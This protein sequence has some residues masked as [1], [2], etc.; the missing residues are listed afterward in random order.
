MYLNIY[1][2]IES[3]IIVYATRINLYLH[4]EGIANIIFYQV[5]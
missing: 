4:K 5:N 1:I 3:S 2:N